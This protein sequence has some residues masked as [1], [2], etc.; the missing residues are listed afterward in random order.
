[1]AV[2]IVSIHQVIRETQNFRTWER[3]FGFSFPLE[4]SE[5]NPQP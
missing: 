1:L 4:D 5:N 3:H 2:A